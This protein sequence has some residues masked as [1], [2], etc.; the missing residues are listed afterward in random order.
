LSIDADKGKGSVVQPSSDCDHAEEEDETDNMSRSE[1][2]QKRQTNK[3]APQDKPS[4]GDKGDHP[5]DPGYHGKQQACAPAAA[6]SSQPV[7]PK[8]SI[9]TFKK[10]YYK[11][12]MGSSKTSNQWAAV[13]SLSLPWL[14][15]WCPNL[16]QPL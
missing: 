12:S 10:G 2:H 1:T 16:P 11:V 9:Y 4:A 6:P 3:T 13:V 7:V 8:E 15:L 14:T 5:Q